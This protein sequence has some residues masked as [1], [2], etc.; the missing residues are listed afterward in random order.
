M[1]FYFFSE[2]MLENSQNNQIFNSIIY[3]IFILFIYMFE[4]SQ[5]KSILGIVVFSSKAT[6]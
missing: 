4:E 6:L 1:S 5:Y 3:D 2:S